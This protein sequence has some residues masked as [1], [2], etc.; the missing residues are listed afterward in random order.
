LLKLKS[1]AVLSEVEAVL[2][3][4]AIPIKNDKRSA[5]DFSGII[6]KK[7]AKLME[8]AIEEGG[9]LVTRELEEE[10]REE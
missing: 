1:E 2:R 7:D 3:K 8:T 4:A 5:H 9:D 10:R 6:S